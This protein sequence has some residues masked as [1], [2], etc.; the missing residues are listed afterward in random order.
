MARIEYYSAEWCGPC[1]M[2]K[3]TVKQ[4]Q[5]EEGIEVEFINI[6]DEDNA[7]KVIEN[8]VR[9]VPTIIVYDDEG[10]KS[11]RLTGGHTTKSQILDLCNS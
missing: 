8:G 5:E 9:N 4:I 1:K 3:P 10:N 6:D 2:L 7:Q 11:G